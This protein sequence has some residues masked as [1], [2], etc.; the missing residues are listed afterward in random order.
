VNY[1]Y[2]T[3]YFIITQLMIY[4]Q[5]NHERTLAHHFDCSCALYGAIDSALDYRLTSFEEVISGKFDMFIKNNLFVGS[6]EFMKEVF[7][8]VGLNEVRLPRNSNRNSEI[9][10]LEQAHKRVANGE[11]LFIKPV[12][13][14]LFTGLILDGMQYSCLSNL[15]NETMVMAYE[16]F[17][18]KIISEWRLYVYNDKLI[19]ARNYSGEFIVSPNYEYAMTVI[20]NN[21]RD[22]PCAYTI[23]IAVLD[24]NE[25][26]VV[27]YNDMWA[28]GNYGIPN[29]IYLKLLKERYFEII[30]W[31]I[32]IGQKKLK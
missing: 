7:K 28:I 21:K 3:K 5:S 8:R 17:K 24:N 12:E 30:T 23:D 16:P 19:D 15:P 11:K 4:I 27:E 20:A 1:E 26:T 29:D 18:N 14:K 9:I 13:I 31:N 2:R 22:F 10:T 32:S 6:T 25:N